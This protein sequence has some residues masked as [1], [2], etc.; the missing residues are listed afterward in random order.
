MLLIVRY[1][2]SHASLVSSN[3][4]MIHMAQSD[5][6]Y[7]LAIFCRHISM[8]EKKHFWFCDIGRWH[9]WIIL[10]ACN[11]LKLLALQNDFYQH[12][13]FRQH[14]STGVTLSSVEWERC[15]FSLQLFWNFSSLE[16]QWSVPTSVAFSVTQTSSFVLAGCR[17]E[18]SI[19]SWGTTT[20]SMAGLIDAYL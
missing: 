12:T 15:G 7:Q 20:T 5:F 9:G 2:E 3:C 14:I 19:H 8:A 13:K 10:L 17:L 1:Y 11:V 6:P 18:P 4:L 16:F